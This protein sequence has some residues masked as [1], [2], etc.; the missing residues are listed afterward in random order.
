MH[1]FWHV[2]IKE[3]VQLTKI[4]YGQKQNTNNLVSC[5]CNRLHVDVLLINNKLNKIKNNIIKTTPPIFYKVIG[6]RY[7]SLT[8]RLFGL[9]TVKNNVLEE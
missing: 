5:I 8:F 2:D 3:S 4:M 6:T 1:A 9:C 7:T